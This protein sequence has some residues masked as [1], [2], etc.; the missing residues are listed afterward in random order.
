MRYFF[1]LGTNPTLSVAEI[2]SHTNLRSRI[3]TNL[4]LITQIKNELK[5]NIESL[6]D[7]V[8]VVK[9]KEI[10]HIESLL[11]G[12]GGTI[13]I[14]KIYTNIT[15]MN[16]NINPNEIIDIIL[17]LRNKYPNK[18]IY[19]GFSLYRLSLDVT[20]KNL[21]NLTWE[22]K[23]LGMEVKRKLKKFGFASR[24]VT[25]KDLALSSVVVKKNKLLTN[26]AEIVILVGKDKIC[27]AKT[28]AVQ[29]FEEYSLRDYGRPSRDILSGIMPP[30]LAK[31]MINLA[32][33]SLDKI[34]L[35]PFC[36]SGTILQEAL[37]MGY[38]NIVG[39]DSNKKAIE[40]AQKNLEWLIN[41][42]KVEGM[43]YK[44]FRTD[45]RRIS[46]KIGSNS[47][48]AIVT[49]PYLGPLKVKNLKFIT[50]ELSKL[51]LEVFQEFKKIL[52]KDGRII[53]IWPIFKLKNRETEKLKNRKTK[54]L[55]DNLLFLPILEEVK[56][57]G[58][59]VIN[60]LPQE[61]RNHPVIKLTNR[62]SIIYS[63]PDQ[64]ILREMFIFSRK[65]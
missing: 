15:R 39:S 2:L 19:F 50:E 54:E 53:M 52:K 21:K 38:K 62:S 3:I 25:S 56:K 37:L 6:S 59:K 17:D 32:Q 30:K 43:R 26:G 14:G 16:T 1:I 42:Y 22:I 60:P 23:K 45:V 65:T 20:P 4:P 61:I 29:E 11:D 31:I 18:K 12:L 28:L 9:S 63:R 5:A 55:K 48:D 10:R 57:L 24:W 35:D 46:K 13:K 41:R 27:L 7:E 47:V 8:L 40:G 58:F 49:E 64:K 34:I 36:G 51:Y 33:I 44:V